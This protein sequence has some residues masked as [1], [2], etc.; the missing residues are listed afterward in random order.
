MFN[1]ILNSIKDILK[2]GGKLVYSTCT[3]D[4]R[5]NEEVVVNFLKE[6]PEFKLINCSK[7]NQVTSPGVKIQG[8]DTIF[9]RRRYPHQFDGE[10][11]F[12]ALLEKCGIPDNE[13]KEHLSKF[14]ADGFTGIFKKDLEILRKDFSL[15]ANYKELDLV[16][17]NDN[18]FIS[19]S[20][21]INLDGLNVLSVGTLL[22]SI[23]K[24]NFKPSH[25]SFHSYPEIYKNHINLNQNQVDKYLQGLEIDLDNTTEGICVVKY[26]NIALG[27]GKLIKGK[28]KN[29][30][31]KEL[32]N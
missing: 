12:M 28:L 24:G 5:E 7:L 1:A 25:N 19:P 2:V 30:Y 31:P 20:T 26:N 3:Y 18:I 13:T 14:S 9:C 4:V 10:G 22:G 32:R 29:Y 21:C 17:K 27:G 16:K 8:Y 11:Q 15:Y 6:N 23:I